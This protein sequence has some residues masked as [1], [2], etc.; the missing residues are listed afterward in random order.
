MSPGGLDE[1]EA[2]RAVSLV[3]AFGNCCAQSGCWN[4]SLATKRTPHLNVQ[5]AMTKHEGR[6][7]I[8]LLSAEVVS[9]HNRHSVNHSHPRKKDIKRLVLECLT[10]LLETL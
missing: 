4:Q 5:F 9:L 10:L 3:C 8:S 6:S 7:R 1:P 2:G